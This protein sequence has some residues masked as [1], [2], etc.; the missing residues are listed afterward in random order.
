[1]LWIKLVINL[2]YT[3]FVLF[4][5]D[6][7]AYHRV[8]IVEKK[9]EEERMK[10]AYESHR[11]WMSGEISYGV[12]WKSLLT[13][14]WLFLIIKC[15]VIASE[16]RIAHLGLSRHSTK[17]ASEILMVGKLGFKFNDKMSW[18]TLQCSQSHSTRVFVCMRK[19]PT[20]RHE[21]THCI[22][23]ETFLI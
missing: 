13:R 7:D 23:K 10:F 17:A 18:I 6:D 16:A 15:Q 14:S 8:R 12:K 20:T 4:V 21:V 5:F 22:I 2:N 9:W 11:A 3:L 1:M 19:R